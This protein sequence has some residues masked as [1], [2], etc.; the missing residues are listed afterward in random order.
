MVDVGNT[1]GLSVSADGR[2]LAFSSQRSGDVNIWRTDIDGGNPKQLTSGGVGS[3]FSPG[4]SPDGQWVVYTFLSERGPTMW[5]IPIDGRDA[6][7]LSDKRARSQAVSPDGR[8]IAC[9]YFGDQGSSAGGLRMAVVPIEG[10]PLVK[11]F[12]VRLKPFTRW[13]SF[14]SLDTIRWTADGRAL[15]YIATHGGVSNI[16]SQPLAGGKPAQLTNFKTGRIF[17]FDWSPDGKWLALARGS[18]TSD[19]VLISDL[20]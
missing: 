17:N 10:G 4:L 16:W 15:T 8:L 11:I 19:V 13:R 2:Y 20:R 18:V 9:S 1:S 5:K 12:D 14:G 7:Q 6:V 3:K